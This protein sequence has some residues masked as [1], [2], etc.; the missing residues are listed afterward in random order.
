M[1]DPTREQLAAENAALPNE[2]VIHERGC[3]ATCGE[4][5]PV[6]RSS[7]TSAAR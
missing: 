5:V 2:V 6:R 4:I 3:C 7:A 1:S